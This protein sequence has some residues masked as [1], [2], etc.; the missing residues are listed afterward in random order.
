MTGRGPIKEQKIF[1]NLV[2]DLARKGPLRHEWPNFSKS[3][4]KKIAELFDVSVEK[5]I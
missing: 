5:F 2:E 4:A 1:A 3:A